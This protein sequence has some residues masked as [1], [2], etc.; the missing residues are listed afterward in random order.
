MSRSSAQHAADLINASEAQTRLSQLTRRSLFSRSGAGLGMAALAS[1]EGTASAAE[2]AAATSLDAGSAPDSKRVG[3]LPNLPH[4]PP[5]AKRAIYLFM[6]GA[7]SQMDMW[8]HKP[9]MADWFDKDLPESIRQGQRLTTMTSGQSRFPIAPSI[10]QFAPHGANGTMASELIPHMAGKVDEISLVKS[11]YTEAIN[12]DPAI[13]YI[14]TGNQLPGKASLG[15]WLSY[16]LGTENANLPAFVVMTAS[17]TGRKQA[18]ALYNRLWGSG[19]LP[20]RYQGVALRSSGDPVLYLSN[21][22]G[23]DSRV[24]RRML[25][26]LA[27]LNG[28]TL[29]R[30]GDPETDARIAQYEMAFRMQTSV[31]DLADLSDEPQHVLDLYGPDVLKPGTYANCCLMSRRLAERGVRF[32]QIFHRGWDQH[33]ALPK[34]LP[35][36]CRDTDQPSA[37]LLTDLK[38]RGMLDDTLV[39]WGGEFGRTIYC[40]GK[41]TKTNYGRDHHPKCF[42]VWMAGAGVRRGLVHGE[43]DEFSYNIVRDGVHIRDLNATILERMGI[44]H[45]RLTYPFQGL[46]QKLTGVEKARVVRELLV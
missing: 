16:G 21:P 12:H 30:I 10:Y 38:Q 2:P 27:E 5:A 15:S 8:D 14:C 19:Y 7:P 46:D 41:L 1:L 40:Q 6:S 13:T 3:G 42:T 37:G 22:D 18:Q 4:H 9:A 45:E 26:T 39:V 25:D 33:G 23:I 11:M 44:D 34:D 32:T 28:E 29:R 36:Q 43:T 31:P 20:S 35:N 17:W 24:R